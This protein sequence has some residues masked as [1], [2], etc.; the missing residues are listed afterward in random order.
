MID[1]ASLNG[2]ACFGGM[3]VVATSEEWWQTSE[4]GR[5]RPKFEG[6]L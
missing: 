5:H 3:M 2:K 6:V 1:K 4:D